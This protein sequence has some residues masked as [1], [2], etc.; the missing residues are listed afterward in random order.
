MH[1]N[2]DA[3]PEPGTTSSDSRRP[4][5]D[6]SADELR[7]WVEARGHR[8]FRA[9]QV[10]EWVIQRRA[11][12][13]EGMTDVP[14]ALRRQLDEGWVVFGTKVAFH[15]VSPDGTDK[16]LLECLDG[17]RIE[18]VLMAEDRRHT[19][20]IST[21]VGCGMGCVFCAS[22]LKGV[23]RNLSRGEILEQVI[24]L[25]NLLPAGESLTNVVV[26]GMGESLANLDNLIAALDVVCSPEGL[27]MGQR[28]VTISTVGLP[29][30]I[31]ELAA[32]DRQYHLAVSLHA[33]TEALRNELV[34]VNEKIGLAAVLEAADDYFRATGRQVTYEYVLLHGINDRP[35]DAEA[36]G[37]RL[38]GRKAHVNLI[39]YN[40]VAGLPYERPTPE[41]IRRFVEVVR[42][43]GI[44]VT[45]RKT[46]GRA[47]DAACGQLRR[48]VEA[49]ATGTGPGS[50]L[51]ADVP[52][53]A[54]AVE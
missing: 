39:P 34:P 31:R 24:R 40:P 48:R 1:P 35:G 2:H 54:I 20:C 51:L 25:R 15:G 12:S 9:R 13:F 7:A 30:K 21:Q 5:L 27:G 4:L 50:P 47:I 33:P 17:R 44:S 29:G 53:P 26:M 3:S 49:E 28:R 6:A 18:C 11:E 38:K 46:K 43:R 14:L 23:E 8:A 16:L 37:S 10:R 41:A 45:V 19:I 42:G 36:L 32:L 52:G 22:G